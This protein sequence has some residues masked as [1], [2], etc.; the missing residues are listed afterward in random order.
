MSTSTVLGDN[1]G[2]VDHAPGLTGGIIA[3]AVGDSAAL[4]AELQNRR[5]SASDKAGRL[6]V[7]P[8]LY[9]TPE[10]IARFAEALSDIL[11]TSPRQLREA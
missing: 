4:A 11:V 6:L 9:N 5:T 8:H 2:G 7:S 10:D 1:R 3:L